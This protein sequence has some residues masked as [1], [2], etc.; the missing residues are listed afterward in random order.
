MNNMI[1]NIL[2]PRDFNG[3]AN[4]EDENDEEIQA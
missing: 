4:V 1:S 3:Q 2:N